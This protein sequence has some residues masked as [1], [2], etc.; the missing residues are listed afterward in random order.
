VVYRKR[1]A[2]A[3]SKDK[4]KCALFFDFASIPRNL[5]GPLRLMRPWQINNRRI[6]PKQG[7]RFYD[8][9]LSNHGGHP[10]A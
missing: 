2:Q 3:N 4:S 5:M 8:D 10:E 6:Y 9:R 1:S 7:D